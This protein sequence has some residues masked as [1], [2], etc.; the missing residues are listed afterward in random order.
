LGTSP[1]YIAAVLPAF[2]YYNPKT[3]GCQYF[4]CFS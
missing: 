4:F 1:Y 3:F 2:L